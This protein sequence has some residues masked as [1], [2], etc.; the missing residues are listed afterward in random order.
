MSSGPGALH[1]IPG[2]PHELCDI[3]MVNIWDFPRKTSQESRC[4]RHQ[5]FIYSHFP[6]LN[7]GAIWSLLPED[8]DLASNQLQLQSISDSDE[9]FLKWIL[10]KHVRERPNTMACWDFL[11]FFEWPVIVEY[12]DV[13]FCIRPN[14]WWLL[15]VFHILICLTCPPTFVGCTWNS[16]R[17]PFG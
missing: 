12:T 2:G 7:L 5:I 17:C 8:G 1:S 16:K 13:F 9:Y 6:V 3:C 14:Y 15:V 11:F 10:S 4:C